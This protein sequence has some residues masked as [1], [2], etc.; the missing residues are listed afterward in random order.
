MKWSELKPSFLFLGK[1][2]GFYL[3]ANF[4]YGWWVT[5]YGS[6]PDPLT[7]LTTRQATFILDL[8]GYAVSHAPHPTRPAERIWLDGHAILSVYEG[9]N[10]MNVW[11][12][13]TGF[14][15]AFT[16]LSRPAL[17]FWGI[18]TIIIY[19]V[20]QLRIL[21]L[22]FISLAYPQSLYF[23]HKYFFT[24]GIYAVVFVLWYY[25]MTRYGKRERAS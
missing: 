15:L 1:F 4:L 22:F 25:W 9:C 17:I 20:N 12:I 2:L 11:I 21:L 24:A 7:V 5:S 10:G 14:I 13:F 16:G 19:W 18:G 23:F 3:I 8:A 6:A